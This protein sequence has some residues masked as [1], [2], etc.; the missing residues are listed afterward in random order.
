MIADWILR[1]PWDEIQEAARVYQVPY[2]LL[3]AIV[4]TESG[5]NPY[6]T[7]YEPDYRY[8]FNTRAFAENT[9]V[10]Q[11][12]EEVHQKTS[13]GLCQVMGGL[14]R[15][16]GFQGQMPELCDPKI[17]LMYACK[18]IKKLASKYG[19]ESDILAA[20]NG[21]SVVKTPGGMYRNQ[22]YVD[23]STRYLRDLDAL[24]K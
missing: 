3:G 4:Q 9:H 16:L 10:T 1:L 17:N 13:W 18:Y 8:L 19:T 2:K 20:Y 12:T 21:G 6:A 22:S 11:P 23:K 24:L 5:G 7:R 14:C 15:E